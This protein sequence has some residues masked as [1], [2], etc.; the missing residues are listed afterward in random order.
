VNELCQIDA[1]GLESQN[2]GFAK[3]DMIF[4]KLLAKAVERD[5]EQVGIEN[6]FFLH[7]P[8]ANIQK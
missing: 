4:N 1:P 3:I 6:E 5:I 2:D 8:N 7:K